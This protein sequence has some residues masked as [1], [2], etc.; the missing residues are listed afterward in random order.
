MRSTT[1][2]GSLDRVFNYG[3]SDLLNRLARL[4]VLFE[5]LRIEWCGLPENI[6]LGDL[7]TIGKDYRMNYFL[8][9]SLVTL[10]EFRDGLTQVLYT[11]D[12]S[13]AKPTLSEMDKEY[14]QSRSVLQGPQQTHEGTPQ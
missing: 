5:D 8:R 9:R 12:F 10:I 2:F 13:R 7:D 11:N 4:S 1:R 3:T 14:H 6:S